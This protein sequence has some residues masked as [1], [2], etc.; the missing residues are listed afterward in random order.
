MKYGTLDPYIIFIVHDILYVSHIPEELYA[1]CR[2]NASL[3]MI[4]FLY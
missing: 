3:S 4:A 2:F 1:Y